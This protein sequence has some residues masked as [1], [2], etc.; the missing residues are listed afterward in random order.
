MPLNAAKISEGIKQRKYGPIA[1]ARGS[2][3]YGFAI[4]TFGAWGKEAVEVMKLLESMMLEQRGAGVT[5]LR[6]IQTI[7][8]AVQAWNAEVC[9]AG[10]VNTMNAARSSRR[11]VEE[12]VSDDESREG[13]DEI[14][15]KRAKH[16]GRSGTNSSMSWRRKGTTRK[17]S[18]R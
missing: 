15:A 5:R 18:F 16:K 2:V 9:K 6:M 11:D 17:M 12:V 1:D 4:E 13:K 14:D 8:I 10:V 3:C 7:S